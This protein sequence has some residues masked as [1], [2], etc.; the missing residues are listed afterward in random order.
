MAV[1]SVSVQKKAS[2]RNF[3]S[4]SRTTTHLIGTGSRPGVY[5]RETPENISRVRSMPSYQTTLMVDHT[6]EGSWL[7][8]KR[9]A[10]L[11][12]FLGFGPGQPGCSGGG[13]SYKTA[14]DL[15]R[16]ARATGIGSPAQQRARD[17]AA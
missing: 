10:C 6:V 16:A 2:V 5:H 9:D 3:P 13:K 4:G 7:R 8:A 17:T 11:F 12:P 1:A 15:K 14:S